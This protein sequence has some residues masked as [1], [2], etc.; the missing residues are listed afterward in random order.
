[1]KIHRFETTGEAYD[2]C[3]CDDI[4][5]GDVI[6]IERERVVGVADTWPFAVTVERGHL[7]VVKYGVVTMEKPALDRGRR[8]AI[9]VA[10][11][12]GFE[13]RP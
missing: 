3:Q 12:L 6:V 10:V 7:H 8:D 9:N 5:D 2:A 13:V 4:D 11:D 1:M